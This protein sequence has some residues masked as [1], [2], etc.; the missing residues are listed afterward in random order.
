MK[1]ILIFLLSF[2]L[3]SIGC[4]QHYDYFILYVQ[5]PNYI[6]LK[7]GSP[8][9]INGYNSG[10]LSGIEKSGTSDTILIGELQF[11]RD[12]MLTMDSKLIFWQNGPNEE[13][14]LELLNGSN[15]TVYAEGDTI[16]SFWKDN[17][18]P[19]LTTDDYILLL[20]ALLNGLQQIVIKNGFDSLEIQKQKIYLRKQI[21]K[22]DS[23]SKIDS[24][25]Q[26]K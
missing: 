8:I 4:G 22:M 26:T 12:P 19:S 15:Q 6:E 25:N 18:A 11:E 24:I 3:S 1:I 21:L 13:R 20:E 2:Y 16:C 5:L 10:E 7:N 14:Q 9:S 17:Y 23:L